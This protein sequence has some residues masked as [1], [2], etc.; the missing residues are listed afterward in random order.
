MDKTEKK[1]IGN[2]DAK[3]WA[4]EFVRLVKVKP[5]IAMDEGTMVGWFANAIMTGYDRAKIKTF[6][7]NKIKEAIEKA[8][9][10]KAKDFTTKEELFKY[11]KEECGGELDKLI[12]VDVRANVLRQLYEDVEKTDEFWGE[13]RKRQEKIEEELKNEINKLIKDIKRIKKERKDWKKISEGS[14]KRNYTK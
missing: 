9:L 13:Y 14:H 1:L 12:T 6:D 2:L 5:S 3:C 8:T 7:E 11:L 10:K 4:E